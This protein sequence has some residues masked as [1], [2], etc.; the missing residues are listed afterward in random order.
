MTSIADDLAWLLLDDDTGRFLVDRSTDSHALGVALE[1][2]AAPDLRAI[3]PAQIRPDHGPRAAA[4]RQRQLDRV[5]TRNAERQRICAV[6]MR[7][8]G[9]FPGWRWPTLDYDS[10]VATRRDIERELF[11][12]T[13][14]ISDPPTVMLIALLDAVHVLQPQCPEHDA[15]SINRQVAD[16]LGR[17]AYARL[18]STVVRDMIGGDYRTVIG[19]LAYPLLRRIPY[20][21]DA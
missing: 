15:A 21:R 13:R 18:P 12:P 2:D 19:D 4:L 16:M 14:R 11:D 10:K 8:F 9:V 5:L 3:T 1:L 17:R 6:P 20:Q 7:R